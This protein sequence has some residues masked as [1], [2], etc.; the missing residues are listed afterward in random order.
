MNLSPLGTKHSKEQFISGIWRVCGTT[1]RSVG[2]DG[3]GSGVV[4]LVVVSSFLLCEVGM[5]PAILGELPS[6]LS[7]DDRLDNWFDYWFDFWFDNW[8]DYWFDYW[9]IIGSFRGIALAVG[10]F[11]LALVLVLL[12]FIRAF[13]LTVNLR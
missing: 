12:I 13:G 8:L 2:F 10:I 6:F 4:G 7:G 5:F 1:N 11:S 3:V 9:L